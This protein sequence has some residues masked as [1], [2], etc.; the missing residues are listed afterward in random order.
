MKSD[1][2]MI[3]N[4]HLKLDKKKW[5]ALAISYM[6]LLIYVSIKPADLN[7]TPS[8]TQQVA[9]NLL[10]VPAYAVLTYLLVQCFTAL[11][12]K[13]AIYAFMISFLFGVLNEF[14]Q[15]FVPSRMASVSD[16]GLNAIGAGLMILIIQKT[17]EGQELK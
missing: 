13:T 9:H 16:M 11:N 6:A 5:L 2:S 14:L 3:L 8:V 7:E 15:S 4:H 10:H 17:S 1:M 12:R